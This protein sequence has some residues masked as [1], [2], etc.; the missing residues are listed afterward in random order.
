MAACTYEL[1]AVNT[2]KNQKAD[3][4]MIRILFYRVIV[5]A[6]LS[7]WSHAAFA[8]S[9]SAITCAI[10]WDAWY[11]NGPNDPGHYTAV[12]LSKPE[13]R[14]RAPLH[15]QFDSSGKITW[16][17][18]QATFDA[19]IRAAH[20]ANFCWAYLVY[21][22][23]HMID[24]ENSMMKGL[25][26]HRSSAI[27]SE[28][29]YA[30]MTQ[31]T[32]LG[33]EN[34]YNDAVNA[35]IQLMRDDN[36]QHISLQG[37][38]RPLLFFFYDP[39]DVNAAFGGS[40]E[41]LKKPIDS[42]RKTSIEQGLGN[43]YIVVLAGPAAKAEAV[44]KALGADAVSQYIAGNRN[45]HVMSWAQFEPTIEADWNHYAA[46]TSADVVPTLR[47]GADIRA[48]CQTSPPFDHRFPPNDKCENYTVNPTNEELKAEFKDALLWIERH[49]EKDPTRLLLVY[50]WSECD[51]SGNCL[52]PTYGDPTGQ[53]LLAIS[54][55]LH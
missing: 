7:F 27:K 8:A 29:K 4:E 46:A 44:R 41:K 25:A 26:F 17:P 24:L 40:L 47:S 6:L 37:A 30:L 50:A 36:Y 23:N 28:V 53:K 35:T 1:P 3:A 42:I 32:L 2:N 48:R 9:D 21:G 22:K 55:V 11:T 10:R 19:E 33:V 34:N 5:T 18:S 12:A 20:G 15:A 16:A 45:G 52:M 13:W 51:E 49:R 31:A 38:S 14:A 54:E 39:G 43:P